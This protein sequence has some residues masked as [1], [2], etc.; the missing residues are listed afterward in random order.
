MDSIQASNW[1]SIRK[2]ID[3]IEE[4]FDTF[5]GALRQYRTGLRPSED[6][7]SAIPAA[8]DR[9]AI[10]TEAV[11]PS[12]PTV[13]PPAGRHE[14]DGI[15][16]AISAPELVSALHRES[17]VGQA[18]PK[19]PLL[20]IAPEL[21]PRQ[22]N[23]LFD[24][25]LQEMIQGFNF[26][27]VSGTDN[28]D[29]LKIILENTPDSV[30][31]LNG[32][33]EILS[34]NPAFCTLFGLIPN[35]TSSTSI[36][37]LIPAEYHGPFA[38]R[39]T[40]FG[41]W[42]RSIGHPPDDILVL[43]ASH[44][45]GSPLSLECLLT[46]YQRDE[47]IVI[48]AIV[49][50]LSFNRALFE[51]LKESKDNYD[52]LSET[53]S[54]AILRIDENFSI[55]F[56]NTAVKSTFGFT[57]EEVRG[58][59]FRMLFPPEI[60]ERHEQE[61]RKY[62]FVDDQHRSELGLRKTLEILGKHK[63][64]GVSPMEMSFGNSK[65][66][67]GRTLTCII[68]DITQRKNVERRLRYL[69]YHD[70]LTGLG[71]RD[72]FLKE[73][74]TLLDRRQRFISPDPSGDAGAA[75]EPVSAASAGP[76]AADI[77]TDTVTLED[78]GY[79]ALMYLDLDGF[80]HVNDT[81][82]HDAGDELLIETARRLRECLRES[83]SVFR[84][85]GD[86]FVVLLASIRH[87]RDAAVVAKKILAAVRRPYP[88]SNMENQGTVN[89]GVSIGIALIPDNGNDVEAITKSA[90]LAMYKAKESGRNRYTFYTKELDRRAVEKWEIEQ[91]IKNALNNNEFLL[92]YQP[93]VDGEGY[94]K[95]L[96]ALIRWHHPTRGETSPGQFIPIAE[97]TGLIIPLGTWVLETA[98]REITFWN[99]NGF[100]DLY[101]SINLSTKQF[102][103]RDMVETISNVILRTGVNPA[104]IKL[105]ITETCIMRNPEA[106]IS[107]MRLLK[108]MHPEIHFAIDDFG[109]G[110]SSLS[111]LSQLP[112][113]ILK[114]DISFVTQ[115][116][117]TH[118]EKIVNAI[119]NLAHSLGLEIVAEGVET[120]EQWK[121][122]TSRDC[123]TLQG[124]HFNKAVS[125]GDLGEILRHHR[126]PR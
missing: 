34:A 3:S 113:D 114:I 35:E 6:E 68:R 77:G 39:L 117:S 116:F 64:R 42:E 98:C 51:Q 108:K 109:T 74:K 46:S 75:P 14:P 10:S 44:Q 111:Y 95:G 7:C 61:F 91:G 33:G 84:F 104:N 53:I 100:P 103:Q 90:D 122:F 52:A 78:F 115:L 54:E 107:K 59:P 48:V 1:D 69:A 24:G 11:R 63:N 36:Y 67:K 30:A 82:G 20:G 21:A 72:L 101:V 106:A 32:N 65:D 41:E 80:K 92:Y 45:D 57:V 119:I 60:F 99:T 110:Y 12:L 81:L 73:M 37:S 123:G 88:I 5:A 27:I 97:E 118:N 49:R 62:F 22:D 85:G 9:T 17:P 126:L 120:V 38:A 15:Y 28:D 83:D 86:E 18:A 79:S 23:S 76:D 29:S 94:I 56:A 124:Y 19:D 125:S 93:L 26:H 105:E 66:Y 70:K 25:L 89:V 31:E 2:R 16:T 13:A 102:D 40:L 87:K 8:F 47:D 43:R 121:Y 4:R 58:R 50:D 55:I 112:A 96:E 71:N